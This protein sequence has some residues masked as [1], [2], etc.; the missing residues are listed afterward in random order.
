MNK[1]IKKVE[2]W[3]EGKDLIKGGYAQT[4]AQLG[5]VKEELEEVEEAITDYYNCDDEFIDDAYSHLQ[6]EMG[7]LLV[8]IIM[9]A[10]NISIDLEQCLNIAYNK[11]SKRT[12]HTIDGVF[13]KDE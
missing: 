6:S 12:G 2:Q 1:L 13:I 4:M 3:G 9:T 11:I 5:K 7:D 10:A 8:T